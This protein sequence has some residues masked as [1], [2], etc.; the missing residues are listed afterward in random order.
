MIRII[1]DV[2]G[3]IDNYNQLIK[4]CDYSVQVGDLGF[5]YSKIKADP[6]C[7]R[8]VGGNHDNYDVYHN[9]S[10]SLGDYGTWQLNGI[11]FFFVRGSV[12][13]DALP[14]ISNYI[15][16]GQ[17]TWW[18]EEELSIEELEDAID[19]YE[20]VQ[21]DIMIT[22]DCPSSIKHNFSS[23]QVM[24]HFGWPEDYSCRT[25]QALSVMFQIHK[26]KLWFFG[27]WHR[28]WH[29]KIDGTRFFCINELDFLDLDGKMKV[30]KN[31]KVVE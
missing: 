14:R 15:L 19:L 31:G 11:E 8:F 2:H 3:K 10:L 12:S 24:K 20:Q 23:P 5:D 21:P 4:Q 30:T 7:H 26:P 27:H 17:K 9:T 29:R 6:A 16:S 22:H 28:N 18:Y 13:I 1:G 25:Q